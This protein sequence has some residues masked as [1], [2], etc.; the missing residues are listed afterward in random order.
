MENNTTL[1]TSKSIRV[2]N[3]DYLYVNTILKNMERIARKYYGS[4]ATTQHINDA[5]LN[6]ARTNHYDSGNWIVAAG[7][8]DTVFT[9]YVAN[10]DPSLYN[11]VCKN[12]I[13]FTDSKK[14]NIDFP[15]LCATICGYKHTSILPKEWSGWQGDLATFATEDVLPKANSSKDYDY[16]IKVSKELLGTDVSHFSKDDI[17][18]DI[19][20]ENIYND[21]INKGLTFLDAFQKYYYNYN[22]LS[23]FD[24]FISNMDRGTNPEENVAFHTLMAGPSLLIYDALGYQPWHQ[25]YPDAMVQGPAIYGTFANFIFERRFSSIT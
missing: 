22:N 13:V 19:D 8:I 7:P 23:R 1:T 5:V 11:L 3:C 20:G 21:M 15:H 14:N 6:L 17:N 10:N 24:I 9:A 4:N 16:L 18:A 2:Y 12:K 25:Y